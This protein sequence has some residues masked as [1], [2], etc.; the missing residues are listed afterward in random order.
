MSVYLDHM[1]LVEDT[2]FIVN[3]AGR[4][5]WTWIRMTGISTRTPDVCTCAAFGISEFSL[6][7]NSVFTSIEFH[8]EF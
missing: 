4:C 2:E 7:R 5:G 3:L 8:M 1:K 6:C